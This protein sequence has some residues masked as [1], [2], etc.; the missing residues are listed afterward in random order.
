MK[1]LLAAILCCIS[2]VGCATAPVTIPAWRPAELDVTGMQR[3]AL[4]EFQGDPSCAAQA[5]SELSVA[6]AA[7]GRDVPPLHIVREMLPAS[8]PYR[9]QELDLRLLV[10]QARRAGFDALLVGE[11]ICETNSH[12]QLIVGNPWIETS[13]ETQLIDL[14]SGSVRGQTNASRRWRGKLSH[15]ESAQNTP[16]KV[17]QQLVAACVEETAGKLVAT[18][19]DIEVA[20]AEP[21]AG[22]DEQAMQA[23]REAAAAGDWALAAKHYQQARA[24]NPDSHAVMYNLALAC[25][26]QF[27]FAAARHWHSEALRQH[28]T[29]EY[30]AAL[31]RVDASWRDYDLAMQQTQGPPRQQLTNLPPQP[32]FAPA[33]WQ[34]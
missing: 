28:E 19:M 27:D 31:A 5:R 20:L 7:G 22:D 9:D 3:I 21:V 15:I 2:F 4:P 26:A 25:E 30:R 18:T 33:G 23:G 17:T 1:S 8:V 11:V 14:R 13:I 29:E 32:N 24:A 34:R 16:R 6:L 12:E 10:G